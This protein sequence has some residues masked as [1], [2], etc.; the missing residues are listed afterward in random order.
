MSIVAVSLL[1]F[2]PKLARLTRVI[3]AD[4]FRQDLR[5]FVLEHLQRLVER[6]AGPERALDFRGIELLEAVQLPRL[7]GL[8][9]GR[10]GGELTSFPAGSG[11]VEILEL[12][13]VQALGSFDLRDDLVAAALDAEA[14][15]VIAAEHGA[16][17]G[18]DLLSSARARRP[19]PDRNDLG[20][21][22]VV[23]QIRIREDEVAARERLADER[24]A[25]SKSSA[26]RPCWR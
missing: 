11:D 3:D 9:Q 4:V 22:H 12:F 26:V 14:V 13:R 16:E 21:R 20:L 2:D 23:F 1:P 24:L 10:E 18:A 15:H 6:G 25:K 5:G 7:G 19:Y 17:I 8:F